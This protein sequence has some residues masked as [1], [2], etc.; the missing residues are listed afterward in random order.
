[1]EQESEDRAL[2]TAQEVADR[3]RV[4]VVTFYRWCRAGMGP[5]VTRLGGATDRYDR[6]DVQAWLEG[7]GKGH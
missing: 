2:L 3:A 6:R 1:M 4:H 5:R 7:P